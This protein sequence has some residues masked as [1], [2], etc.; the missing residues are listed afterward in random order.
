MRQLASEEHMIGFDQVDADFRKSPTGSW[1][2]GPDNVR[3]RKSTTQKIR[4]DVIVSSGTQSVG[5]EKE[6]PALEQQWKHPVRLADLRAHSALSTGA[7]NSNNRNLPRTATGYSLSE[8]ALN[9]SRSQ[10]KQL[11]FE[12]KKKRLT[13]GQ[14][15]LSRH[16]KSS[17]YSENE[18]CAEEELT[19]KMPELVVTPSTVSGASRRDTS[20]L[21]TPG[22]R[23]YLHVYDLISRDTLMLLPPFGCLVEIGQCFADMNTALHQLGTGAYHVGIEVNG[24][25][26]AYGA[27]TQ[28]GRTGV[29][30]CFPKMSP[31]Y[32]YRTSINLGKRPQVRRKVPVTNGNGIVIVEE[33]TVEATAVLKEMAFEYLGTDYDI[34]RKNCCSFACDASQRFGVPEEEIPSWFRNLAESG[35][36]TQDVAIATVQP[37]ARVLSNFEDNENTVVKSQARRSFALGNICE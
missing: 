23:I 33:R 30:T 18:E 27:A 14:G 9:R 6:S 34:L 8:E 2:G 36:A 26:Y 28:P 11:L 10:R 29:F 4:R 19:D 12:E 22:N 31:G 21:V 37:I 24:V 13:F 16:S 1:S 35:A 17:L 15:Q 20:S 7:E 5:T 3:D 32:Q 25:E